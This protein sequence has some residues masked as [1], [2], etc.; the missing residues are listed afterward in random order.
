MIRTMIVDD[1]GVV[2]ALIQGI[3]KNDGRFDVVGFA[4]NGERAIRRNEELTP[5]L[6]LMDLKMPIM[7]GIEAS[8]KIMSVSSPTIVAFTS[9]DD[10]ETGYRCLEAGA[11]DI[12]KKPAV[13]KMEESLL[14]FFCD[15]LAQ[16]VMSR[17]KTNGDNTET[18]F[19][20]RESDESEEKKESTEANVDTNASNDNI[21]QPKETFNAVQISDWIRHDYKMIVMGSSTGGPSTLLEIIK[22]M[23]P[24]FPL[25]VAITQH[26]DAGFDEQL[27]HWLSTN[28]GCTVKL[29]ED[30]EKARSGIFYIAPAQKHLVIKKDASGE[31]VCQFSLDDSEAI[32]F[33]KPAVDKLFT[34]ASEIFGRK[35]I[36]V[37]LTGMGRD[38]DEG[39]ASVKE[40]GGYTIC[41]DEAS[42]VVYGMPRAAIENG[43]AIAVK[44]LADI[45][46]HIREII[47]Q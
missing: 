2:R 22:N 4:D 12:I 44:A 30:G 27:A 7:D 10:A 14:N 42:C 19:A 26:I 9:E 6:I 33:L 31:S 40:K 8:K 17:K 29:A 35:L 41:E 37:L 5:E 15:R 16:I 13:D 21:L 34:S 47:G 3:L 1:S 39:C 43:H 28:T 11:V 45:V 38:G 24:N 25:P 23:G 20:E 18:N 46:P 36:A 32:H